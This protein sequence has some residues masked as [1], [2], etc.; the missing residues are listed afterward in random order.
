MS[1]I[2]TELVILGESLASLGRAAGPDGS[3]AL[4]KALESDKARAIVWGGG[5]GTP[6]IQHLEARLREIVA[7]ALSKESDKNTEDRDL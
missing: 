5:D 1:G 2:R 4:R 7:D 3:P 6:G